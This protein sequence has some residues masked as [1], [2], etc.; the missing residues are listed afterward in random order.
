M[1]YGGAVHAAYAG[2]PTFRGC[3]FEGNA[4][5]N[6][7]GGISA[8]GNDES[9]VV[10]EVVDCVFQANSSPSAG[11]A[12]QSRIGRIV[13]NEC[14]IDGNQAGV[15]GGCSF[16]NSSQSSMAD[17][18]VCGNTPDQISGLFT[19]DGGNNISDTC[20]KCPADLSGDGLVNS[21]DLG[22]LLVDWAGD[23]PADLNGD[24][25]VNSADVGLL[26]AGW[27]MCF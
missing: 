3:V 12:I 4:A 27:G 17:S 15:G 14:T 26:L 5:D 24:G 23:G 1:G 6:G 11:G 25:E 21:E 10:V 20:N 19:D 7:G 9:P 22:L 2:N 13:L 8:V 18:T 16:E